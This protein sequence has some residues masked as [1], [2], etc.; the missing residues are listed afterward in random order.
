MVAFVLVGPCNS[1]G[2]FCASFYFKA[3]SDVPFL[4]DVFPAG[5]FVKV[6]SCLAAVEVL[7]SSVIE[8]FVEPV[9]NCG[10]FIEY[11]G[12][13]EL[14]FWGSEEVGFFP[15]LLGQ[16]SLCSGI[17]GGPSPFW[18]SFVSGAIRLLVCCGVGFFLVEWWFCRP[19]CVVL[20]LSAVSP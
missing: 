17:F 18:F 14:T 11:C 1:V 9:A 3:D 6:P 8:V 10:V 20:G 15:L 16:P 4:L 12:R 13:F 7:P 2:I 5:V 19:I